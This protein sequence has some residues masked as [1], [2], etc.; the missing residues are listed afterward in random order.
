MT[1]AAI[2]HQV[3]GLEER[4]GMALFRRLPRGLIL[5]E[6]AQALLPDLRDAFDRMT[7]ALERVGRKAN[8][9]TLNVS[10]VTT[11]AL[12]WLAAAFAP[13]PH[14][15]LCTDCGISRSSDP[16]RC[17]HACQ[18]IKPEYEALEPQPQSDFLPIQARGSAT[19]HRPHHATRG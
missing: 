17:G 2:S 4:L 18:F 19:P 7:N 9:G 3:K 14:R 8:S 5:T 11:F 6:D 10:L 1:Q 16:K 13:A 15:E 12:G